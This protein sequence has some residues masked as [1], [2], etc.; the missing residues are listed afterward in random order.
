M[1]VFEY[2][3]CMW[4]CVGWWYVDIGFVGC[5]FVYGVELML[6]KLF[7]LFVCIVCMLLW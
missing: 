3:E 4:L 2:C 5:G 7:E 6:C 1:Y